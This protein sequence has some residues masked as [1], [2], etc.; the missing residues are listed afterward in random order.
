MSLAAIRSAMAAGLR[1]TVTAAAVYEYPYLK[2]GQDSPIILLERTSTT[3]DVAALGGA[4]TRTHRITAHVFV[5]FDGE[6]YTQQQS[7]ND[8]DACEEAIEAW[9]TANRTGLFWRRLAIVGPTQVD[10]VPVQGGARRHAAIPLE[11]LEV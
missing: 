1:A 3:R 2:L 6:N 4:Y 7:E 5:A 9:A 8:L 10:V 11:V